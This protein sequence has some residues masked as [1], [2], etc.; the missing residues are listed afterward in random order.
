MPTKRKPEDELTPEELPEIGLHEG[1]RPISTD[2]YLDEDG[3]CFFPGPDA[4]M[5]SALRIAPPI[6]FLNFVKEVLVLDNSTEEGFKQIPYTYPNPAPENVLGL[7]LNRGAIDM[8]QKKYNG[9]AFLLQAPNETGQ[10][11]T[12]DEWTAEFKTDGLD[13]LSRMRWEWFTKGGG[14][15]TPGQRVTGP[16]QKGITKTADMS[17]FKKIGKY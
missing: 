9:R 12:L 2:A 16:G 3:I 15:G 7:N 6:E 13:V 10:W 5:P 8:L 4:D 17:R 1:D 14:V 11:M